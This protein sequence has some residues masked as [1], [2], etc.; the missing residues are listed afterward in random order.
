MGKIKD[1][2]WDSPSNVFDTLTGRDLKR[3]DK[4]AR[5]PYKNIAG[6]GKGMTAQQRKDFLA[7]EKAKGSMI[8]RQGNTMVTA[9]TPLTDRYS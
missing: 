1:I 4:K 3:A 2:F 5:N 9:R 6:G 7:R 8:D